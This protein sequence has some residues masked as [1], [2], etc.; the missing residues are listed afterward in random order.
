M[1]QIDI[2]SILQNAGIVGAGGAG[3]PAYAKLADAADTLCI[4]CAECEPLMYTDYMLMRE[5]MSKIVEGAQIVM[6]NSNITHTYISIKEHRAHMLG[7]TDGQ[8]VGDRVSIKFL[9]NVYPMGDEINLIY[10]ILLKYYYPMASILPRP[11]TAESH[12]P[13][14][15][16]SYEDSIRI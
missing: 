8:I 6:D 10:E 11:K 1:S 7:Y 5:E 15:N 4:N 3:F 2:K 12:H 13:S 14:P 16:I 9:P